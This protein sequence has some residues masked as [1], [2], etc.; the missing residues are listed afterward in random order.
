MLV[1]GNDSRYVVLKLSSGFLP[2]GN[3]V[4]R[5]ALC[6]K[7]TTRRLQAG[8]VGVVHLVENVDILRLSM[9]S[10]LRCCVRQFVL[11]LFYVCVIVLKR[12]ASSD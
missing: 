10:D 4:E 3:G 8:K 9:D 6:A 1:V 12:I 2:C 11:H 7:I 5:R